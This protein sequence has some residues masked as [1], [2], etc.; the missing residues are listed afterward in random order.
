MGW[1]TEPPRRHP[2]G[3]L[4]WL[5]HPPTSHASDPATHVQ[6]L[7]AAG[8]L[9]AERGFCRLKGYRQMPTFVA[10]LARHL[11]A[12]TPAWDAARVA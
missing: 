4:A 9:N 2:S 6:E 12:V 5:H 8:M 3:Q 1:Q 10:A 11:Q 7:C